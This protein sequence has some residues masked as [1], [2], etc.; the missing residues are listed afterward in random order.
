MVQAHD[1][2]IQETHSEKAIRLTLKSVL[3]PSFQEDEIFR[4]DVKIV[5]LKCR[6]GDM[7]KKNYRLHQRPQKLCTLFISIYL[8]ISLV[9]C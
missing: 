7:E 8:F 1:E 2:E 6:Q 9:Y 3:E 5:H 4:S